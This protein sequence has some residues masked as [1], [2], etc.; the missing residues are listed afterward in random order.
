MPDFDQLRE[1]ARHRSEQRRAAFEATRAR[2]GGK[3]K[4]EIREIYVSELQR[5]GLM[6]PADR[7]LD[8]V[9]ERVAGNPIPG[10]RVAGES[11]IQM[12]KKLSDVA[13][14]LRGNQ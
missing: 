8:A 2:A 13:R 12:G 1:D 4:A 14:L 10:F 11:L 6:V 5:R 3:S 7:I 9:A